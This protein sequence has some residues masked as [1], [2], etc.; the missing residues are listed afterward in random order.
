MVSY[1]PRMPFPTTWWNTLQ[2]FP[3]P[4]ASHL[5]L[6]VWDHGVLCT[7]EAVASSIIRG[8]RTRRTQSTLNL[9]NYNKMGIGNTMT[10]IVEIWLSG[11]C[12]E[13]GVGGTW[14]ESRTVCGDEKHGI[15]GLTQ[16][17]SQLLRKL[18]GW[19][20]A[21]SHLFLI[22]KMGEETPSSESC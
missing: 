22:W 21:Q 10:M 3:A 8:E 4:V 18:P 12:Q 15:K 19:L 1:L 2:G 13:V 9:I 6:C 5:P 11:F 7:L 14:A 17:G 20:W 16:F